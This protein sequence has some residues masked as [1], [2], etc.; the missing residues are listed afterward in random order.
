MPTHYRAL[1]GDRVRFDLKDVACYWKL[2]LLSSF[3]EQAEC[4]P[5]PPPLPSP[6]PDDI[7]SECDLVVELRSGAWLLASHPSPLDAAEWRF[8]QLSRA[9]AADALERHDIELPEALFASTADAKAETPADRQSRP[10]AADL[11]AEMRA[12][13]AAIKMLKDGKT[14]TVSAVAKA[15]GVNRQHLYECKIFMDFM[16]TNRGDKRRLPRGEKD[17]KTGDVEAYRDEDD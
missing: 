16:N 13:A 11:P 12:L 15:A 6:D 2:S 4:G 5:F 3:D 17:G 7:L 1:N 8:R 9:K 14:P 10:E